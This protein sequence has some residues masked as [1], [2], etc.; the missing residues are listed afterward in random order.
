VKVN[1]V[2]TNFPRQRFVCFEPK[3][4]R[5]FFKV[6][7]QIKNCVGILGAFTGGQLRSMS[8]PNGKPISDN[9]W[10]LILAS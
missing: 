9:I 7:G 3:R 4:I 5:D 2:V 8:F 1:R 6:A 10:H